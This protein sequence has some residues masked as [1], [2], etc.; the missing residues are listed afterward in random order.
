MKYL[1][2]FTFDKRAFELC[3]LF[4]MNQNDFGNPLIDYIVHIDYLMLF[5][6]TF[7]KEIHVVRS[8]HTSSLPALK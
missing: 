8:E 5:K 4:R 7:E 6:I 1:S 2:I 3:F